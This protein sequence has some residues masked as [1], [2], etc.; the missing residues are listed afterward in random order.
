MKK[1]IITSALISLAMISQA[2]WFIGGSLEY[3]FT[4]KKPERGTS[5]SYSKFSFAPTVGYQM[6]KFAFGTGFVFSAGTEIETRWVYSGW[7]GPFSYDV[8]IESTLWGIQ[9][10]VHYTF[11][12]FGKFSIFANAGLHILGGNRKEFNPFNSSAVDLEFD[13]TSFGI[14]IVPVLSYNLSERISLEAALN[15]MNFGWNRV[16]Q[17]DKANKTNTG[18]VTNFGF[19]IN[20]GNVANVS[21][22]SF[23][24]IYKF[25]N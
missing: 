11:V 25:K 12:E 3:N 19:G 21:A 1:I 18:T 16:Y 4:S 17:E 24:F 22:L 13:I 15:F 2:Q 6:Y 14:N 20:T 10:F 8:K 23:G 5:E 7:W 9:P